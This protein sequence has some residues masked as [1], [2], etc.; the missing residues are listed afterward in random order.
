LAIPLGNSVE[1]NVTEPRVESR[2]PIR[3]HGY[4]G[5]EPGRAE[6]GRWSSRCVPLR[7]AV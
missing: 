1:G 2:R 6:K 7:R 3:G 4:L 5:P